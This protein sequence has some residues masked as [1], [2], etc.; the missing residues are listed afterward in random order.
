M[1][2]KLNVDTSIVDYLKSKGQKS[3]YDDR[4]KLAVQRGIDGYRGTAQQNV[5]LLNM[6]KNQS[7]AK[8]SAPKATPKAVTAPKVTTPKV[9]PT[10]S[11]APPSTTSLKSYSAPQITMPQTQIK[12]G[13][14]VTDQLKG[15]QD[16]IQ[17]ALS[18]NSPIVA[19]AMDTGAIEAK[20]QGYMDS[21]KQNAQGIYDNS[22]ASQKAFI[23]AS[24]ANQINSLKK[25]YADAVAQGEISQ[26]E[27]EKQ[28]Q[29]NVQEIQDSAYLDAQATNIAAEARGIGNSQQ[30]L[31][32][33]AGDNARK[34]R[35]MQSARS[36]RDSRLNDIQSRLDAITLQ[37]DLDVTNAQTQG[38]LQY[39]Q[40]MTGLQSQLMNNNM[41][42]DQTAYNQIA[43][44]EKMA[45]QQGFQ[46]SMAHQN[47]LWNKENMNMSHLYDMEKMGTNQMYTQDNMMMNHQFGLENMG[48][49][50]QYTQDNM[51][52]QQG[53]TQDN[54]ALNQGYT[55]ENMAIQQGYTQDNMALSQRYTLENMAKQHG[56]DLSK[57]SVQQKYNLQ[58]MAKKQQYDMAQISQ[59]FS[60]SVSLEN[61]RHNNNMSM[62]ALEFSQAKKL[63]QDKA[64][65]QQR[66]IE[67]EYKQARQWE[68]NKYRK[69]TP[70][71][72]IL[73][74][75]MNTEMERIK[76]EIETRAMAEAI[77]EVQ[78]PD[79]TENEKKGWWDRLL[80]K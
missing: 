70:E 25:A 16:A 30:M 61:L 79:T 39:Q 51:A 75:Q 2:Q 53:Y 32:M 34:N 9:T 3:S 67:A 56:Y 11:S 71:Y 50:Q 24:V 7:S 22:L 29:S 6:L 27:A 21:A 42:L 13:S 66:D 80:G 17:R 78:K 31:G 40:A 57:M 36:D 77:A 62:S 69:G 58:S 41:M 76:R 59:Q 47:Q 37:K 72:T 64:K 54:M 23:D 49:Q 43:D 15:I 8:S 20:L 73:Q 48:W 4:A 46:A 68:L 26:N 14:G 12:V 35:N 18:T 45:G 63:A 10:A 52:L 44:I 74:G 28:F 60:N 65:A 55:K 5:T 38:D 33:M 1:A 19:S